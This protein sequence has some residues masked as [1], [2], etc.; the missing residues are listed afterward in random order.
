MQ[1]T[2]SNSSVF[3]LAINVEVA[4]TVTNFCLFMTLVGIMNFVFASVIFDIAQVLGFVFVL[5]GNLGDINPSSLM[6]FLTATMTFFGGLG[7]KLICV[8][9]RKEIVGLSLVF[10]PILM[11]SIGLV[12]GFLG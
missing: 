8:S 7:L 9:D 3:L 4:E 12:L 5:L 10:I 1:N 11:F 2:C 6:T